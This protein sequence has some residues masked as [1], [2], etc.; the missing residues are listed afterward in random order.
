MSQNQQATTGTSATDSIAA[1]MPSVPGAQT[2]KSIIENAIHPHDANPTSSVATANQPAQPAL[3]GVGGSGMPARGATSVAH[4]APATAFTDQVIEFSLMGET[5]TF[6]KRAVVTEE[7]QLSKRPFTE[8]KSVTGAVR[9]ER[10]TV[11]GADMVE[12]ADSQLDAPSASP[13]QGGTE[14]RAGQGA[15]D[16]LQDGAQNAQ[17]SAVEAKHGLDGLID[18]A[19][20]KLF[21]GYQ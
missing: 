10:V 15:Q 20:G 19:V 4:P 17:Q 2:A 9:R 8:Q 7:V 16:T 12:G 11:E 5:L 6:A 1:D 14:Q 3:A 21:G 18:G 13:M